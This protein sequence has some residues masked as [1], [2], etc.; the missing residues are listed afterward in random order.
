VSRRLERVCPNG[1][2]R[3]DLHLIGWGGPF[4]CLVCGRCLTLRE[5]EHG[6]RTLAPMQD[7]KDADPADPPSKQDKYLASEG[8]V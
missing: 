7:A 5:A 8:W 4:V 2:V 6:G 3:K 1:H